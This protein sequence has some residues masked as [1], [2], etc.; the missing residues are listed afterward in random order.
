MFLNGQV[1]L[2]IAVVNWV[3]RGLTFVTTTIA[4]GQ[5][6]QVLLQAHLLGTLVLLTWIST[7]WT[8]SYR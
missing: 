2:A 4:R 5:S 7:K 3:P 8:F 1:A 6:W